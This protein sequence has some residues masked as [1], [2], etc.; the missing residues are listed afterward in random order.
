MATCA[1]GYLVTVGGFLTCLKTDTACG[2]G[3]VFKVGK[4]GSDAPTVSCVK[5]NLC[6][7]VMSAFEGKICFSDHSDDCN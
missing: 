5:A 1:S 6:T 2:A 4:V 7:D 3:E